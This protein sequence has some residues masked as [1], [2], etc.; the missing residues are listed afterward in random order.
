M[1]GGV[2]AVY[3]RVGDGVTQLEAVTPAGRAASVLIHDDPRSGQRFFADLIAGHTA[4]RL[5]AVTP[6]GKQVLTDL[7]AKIAAFYG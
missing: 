4:R 2:V 1:G 3:G 6:S 7:N 5:T